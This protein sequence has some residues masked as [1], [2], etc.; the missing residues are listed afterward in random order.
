MITYNLKLDIAI[1]KIELQVRAYSATILLNKCSF[2]YSLAL[3]E[4]ID[5]NSSHHDTLVASED[6]HVFVLYTPARAM[7]W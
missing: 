1:A 5:A 7:I 3:H 2:L 6:K 4:P